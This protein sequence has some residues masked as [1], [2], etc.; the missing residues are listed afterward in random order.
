MS[1]VVCLSDHS[2]LHTQ[3]LLLLSS[4]LPLFPRSTCLPALVPTA[5]APLA[6]A[7]AVALLAA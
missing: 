7:T 1:L 3:T 5:V 2:L 6:A 4:V